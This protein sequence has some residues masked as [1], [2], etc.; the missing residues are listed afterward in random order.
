MT[1]RLY[2]FFTGLVFVLLAF[3]MHQALVAAPTEAAMGDAQRLFYLHAPAAIAGLVLFSC[4]FI[5]SII[6]LRNRS[7][8]ADAWAVAAAEVGVV[9]AT[10]FLLTGSIWT[11]Y[12]SGMWWTWDLR[13]ATSL[14]LWLLYVSYLMLRSSS[15]AG[16]AS[17]MS[18]ALAV[19]AFLDVPL[20][21]VANRWFRANQ[22]QSIIN[23]GLTPAMQ[24]ALMANVIG[25]LALAA[26]LC[27]SRFRLERAS[28]R[29][30][31]LHIQKAASGAGL[32]MALP[33]LFLF[34]TP[35][36]ASPQAFMYGGYLAAW[37]VYIGYLAL[38]VRKAMR[39]RREE[40]ELGAD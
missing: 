26:L 24:F 38:L 8:T 37:T 23:S 25:F 32:A 3:G 21:Y 29:V 17:I 39:L 19:F 28:Q 12:A 5:A 11:R 4:N 7:Q 10:V 13:L 16:S 27:W 6:Y 14:I 34:Q 31:T 1:T 36:R 20:A 18:A 22:A 33:A 9:F 40:G 30:A 15:E 35:H 2:S